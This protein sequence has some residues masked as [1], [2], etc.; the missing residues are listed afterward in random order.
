MNS[1]EE[2]KSIYELFLLILD[3]FET[4]IFAAGPAEI[5][6]I[7]LLILACSDNL[8]SKLSPSVS[9]FSTNW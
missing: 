4:I 9:Q 6:N 2:P 5:K 7:W 1:M 8:D 3:N